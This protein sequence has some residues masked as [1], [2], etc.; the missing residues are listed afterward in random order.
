MPI[1]NEPL[2]CEWPVVA[3]RRAV[4]V[5]VRGFIVML[6]MRVLMATIVMMRMRVMQLAGAQLIKRPQT[7]TN[8][9]H[10]DDFLQRTGQRFGDGEFQRKQNRA[11]QQQAQAVT[12]GPLNAEHEGLLGR[13]TARH[14]GAD[15]GH[16]IGFESVR[17]TKTQ[18][19]PKSKSD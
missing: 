2:P 13:R 15:S 9:H 1:H 3:V 11:E 4:G 17:C 16:V 19:L 12:D 6:A 5:C 10:A 7:K 14:K 18:A 8:Q